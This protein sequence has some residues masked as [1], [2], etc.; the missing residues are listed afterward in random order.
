MIK[1]EIL[2][3]LDRDDLRL[4]PYWIT[5]PPRSAP[6]GLEAALMP[7]PGPGEVPAAATAPLP[8]LSEVIEPQ[9]WQVSIPVAEAS[10]QH[11]QDLAPSKPPKLYLPLLVSTDRK[12]KGDTESNRGCAPLRSQRKGLFLSQSPPECLS[13]GPPGPPQPCAFVQL[14]L[15]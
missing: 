15:T 5:H 14:V 13:P 9:L 11:F 12:G 6:P 8:A 10:G 1:K 3:D 4:P 2:Q 7:D